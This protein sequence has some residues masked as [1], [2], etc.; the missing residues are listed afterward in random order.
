MRKY[1]KT[2]LVITTYNWP[3]ALSL[4]L[5]SVAQQRVLPGEVIVADDGSTEATRRLIDEVRKDF[6]VP[7]IHV[8]QEDMGYRKTRIVNKAVKQTSGEYLIFTDGDIIMHPFF[9]ADHV[10]NIH[11]DYFLQ[12]SRGMLTPKKTALLIRT[13]NIRLTPFSKGI[14]NRLNVIRSKFLSRFIHVNPASPQHIIGCNYSFWKKDYIAAN[15]LNNSFDNSWGHDDSEYAAR[16]INNGVKRKKIK[17]LAVCYHQYHPYYA[18]DNEKIH[19]R[20]F[21]KTVAGKIKRCENGYDQV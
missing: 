4:C 8:W 9:I 14:K 6:P 15:G 21:E 20:V 5:K 13:G 17:F 19:W 11:P 16:L 3:E 1:P 18:H 10:K 2:S 12:G 7:L